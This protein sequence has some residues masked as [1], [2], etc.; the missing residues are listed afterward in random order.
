LH[1]KLDLGMAV[2]ALPINWNAAILVNE[3][4]RQSDEWDAVKA[5]FGP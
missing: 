1:L 5:L 4:K 3:D 2:Q